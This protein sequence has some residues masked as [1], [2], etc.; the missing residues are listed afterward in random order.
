MMARDPLDF[1][2][3]SFAPRTTRHKGGRWADERPALLDHIRTAWLLAALALVTLY[4]AGL[5]LFGDGKGW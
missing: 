5:Y 4:S 1:H 3:Q 2:G